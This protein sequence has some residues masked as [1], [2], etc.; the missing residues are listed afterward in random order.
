MGRVPGINIRQFSTSAGSSSTVSTDGLEKLRK[1][2]MLS[3]SNPDFIFRDKLS[4]ILY[5]REIFQIAFDK[6]KSKPGNM[7]PGILPTTLDGLSI[8]VIDEI[9]YS[10]RKGAFRF[11]PGRRYKYLKQMER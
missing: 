7:T 4:K 8:E 6:L 1:I 10:L 9:I 5:D 2:A 3:K 11:Q